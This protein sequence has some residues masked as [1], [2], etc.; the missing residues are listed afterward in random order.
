MWL[1]ALAVGVAFAMVLYFRNRKQHYGKLLT[2]TL[3][4]L[5]TLIGSVVTMLLFN[6]YFR[7]RVS[8]L[9]QPTVVLAHD[10]SA[11][12]VLS[13]DS[14]FYMTEYPALFADFRTQLNRGFQVD[15]YLF[16]QE[17]RDFD[18][19]DF[20]DQ[21]TDV[22]A[23]LQTTDRRYFKRNVGAVVLLSDGV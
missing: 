12:V 18:V 4:A 5:R 14:V 2:V 17:V 21:L 10:N 11:S 20:T 15:E 23:L 1:I 6:P 13:N 7:Q 22:S 19:L 8:A 3:F 16:G 9:E